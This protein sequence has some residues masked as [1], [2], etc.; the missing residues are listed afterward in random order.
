M[1]EKH[2]DAFRVSKHDPQSTIQNIG[3]VAPAINRF[4]NSMNTS[5]FTPP[6]SFSMKRICHFAVTAEI[7]LRVLKGVLMPTA[8]DGD[9]C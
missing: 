6:F 5:P 8:C 2:A 1:L 3:R 4:K 9:S 7:G